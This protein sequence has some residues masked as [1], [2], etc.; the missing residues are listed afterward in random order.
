[1]IRRPPRSTLFP[2]TTLFRSGRAPPAPRRGPRGPRPRP[3]E[4]RAPQD[5]GDARGGRARGRRAP[6][7]P[8]DPDAQRVH[9]ARRTRDL[10]REVRRA[11][12]ALSRRADP[13]EERLRVDRR[14]DARRAPERVAHRLSAAAPRLLSGVLESRVQGEGDARVPGSGLSGQGAGGA[15]PPPAPRGRGEGHLTASRG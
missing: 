3:T 6:A 4:R 9:P 14:G 7:L 15:P 10:S 8:D 12:R 1:M 2:Y 5:D 13:S 11:P